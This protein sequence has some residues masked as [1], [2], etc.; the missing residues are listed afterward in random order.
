QPAGRGRPGVHLRHPAGGG[1]Q[2]GAV[3]SRFGPLWQ[4]HPRGP[5]PALPVRG[6]PP[7][8]C[9]RRIRTIRVTMMPI[10]T[11]AMTTNNAIEPAEVPSSAESLP[12]SEPFE[13]ALAVSPDGAS[14]P[15]VAVSVALAV[16]LA[17]GL[18]VLSG[19][20]PAAACSVIVK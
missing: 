7:G 10:T 15:G 5:E 2:H 16:S 19:L 18:S 12:S 17:S 8:H 4:V 20:S 6:R 13:S 14:S 3:R 9:W 1:D 11:R